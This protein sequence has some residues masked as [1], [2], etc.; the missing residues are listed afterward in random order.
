MRKKKYFRNW[1]AF[2]QKRTVTVAVA[3]G[4]EKYTIRSQSPC[5]SGIPDC[6]LVVYKLA[7]RPLYTQKQKIFTSLHWACCEGHGGDN[8]EDTV[9]DSQLGSGSS[10]L[11]GISEPE[12]QELRAPDVYV[13]QQQQS[14]SNREQNDYHSSVTPTYEATDPT[15]HPDHA[16]NHHPSSNPTANS[17]DWHRPV[18]E[19]V[20]ATVK[21]VSNPEATAA[22][23]PH[24]M[25]LVMSQL[26]PVLEGFNRS[27]E[28]LSR[29]V[30]SLARDVAQLKLPQSYSTELSKTAEKRLD[31]RLDELFQHLRNIRGQME[32]QQRDMESR[33]H[34]QHAMLHYNFTSLKTDI[35]MKLKRHQ[36]MLQVSLQAMNATVTELKLDH[37]QSSEDH[38]PPPS[39]S[40]LHPPQRSDSSGLWEAI[41]RLDNMVV[42]NTVKVSGLMEDVEVT[43]GNVQQLKRDLKELE[44]QVHHTGRNSQILFMETGLEVEE[45][46]VAVLDRVNELAKNLTLQGERLQETEDDVDYLY[47]AFYNNSSSGDCTMLKAAVARLEKAVANVTELANENKLALEENPEGAAQQWGRDS[48]WA[49]AVKALQDGLQQVKESLVSEQSETRTLNHRL[50]QLSSS[51]NVSVEMQRL[52]SSFDSLLR[53]AIRHSDVL[54][55]L[56]G[57]EV[58]EFLEWSEQDQEAHSIPALKQ[59]LRNQALKITSLLN[60]RTGGSGEEPSADQ[61]SSSHDMTR[62]GG[63]VAARERQLLLLHPQPRGP[64][65]RG[66]G[67]DLWN[68]EKM[69]EE[70]GQK[71]HRLEEKPCWCPN[72]STEREAPPG[73]VDAKLQAEVMWLKKGLEDHLSVFKNVF[74]NAD[75]LAKSDA[76]LELNKL[77]ELVKNEDGKKEKKRRGG[78]AGKEGRGGNHRSKK[79]SSG[80]AP[81]GLPEDSLLFVAAS[82]RRVSNGGVMFKASVN[83]GQFHPNSGTFTAPVDGIYLFIL[84]L[85]L[86]PG[87]VHVVLRRG[88]GGAPLSLH[89]QKVAVPGPVTG[90]GLLL[91]REAEEVRLELRR[92]AWTETEDNVFTGLLVH[93]TTRSSPRV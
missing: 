83:L 73:G 31:H 38:L 30:G 80:V 78:G 62:S 59:Q 26:Q 42:N 32:S 14:N 43:S 15:H 12:S 1:C 13:R 88:S 20:V 46:K 53:D 86:R 48:D 75:V 34:S 61:P 41:E 7:T 25:A 40:P 51:V 81:A 65:Y 77:W 58:L 44:E 76:T 69:M 68:L 89:R 67:S 22:P 56:L 6:Q 33:L 66:D 24:M 10:D 8:C 27:L 4:T 74:S 93:R 57:E 16:P 71:V 23:L 28:H 72:I 19:E 49:L 39:L 63:G 60:N 64:E 3:C 85:T 90:V 47:T 54:E 91:L 50:T 84:T 21:V 2:V 18:R 79:D 11:S 37:E 29:Q 70:L 55:L 45:A 35:D 17:F 52:S 5:P 92:G 82:P 36:K 9:P 87:P